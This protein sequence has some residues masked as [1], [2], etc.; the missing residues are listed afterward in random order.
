[1]EESTVAG[2]WRY[3]WKIYNI[4][5]TQHQPV[6]YICEFSQETLSVYYC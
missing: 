4:N 2:P 1:M 5:I 3:L 6:Y